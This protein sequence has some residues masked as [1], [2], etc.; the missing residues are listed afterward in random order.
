VFSLEGEWDG[1]R[2]FMPGL[3]R[4]RD[5][6]GAVIDQG[7]LPVTGGKF[8]YFFDPKRINQRVPTYDIEYRVNGRAELGD[9]VHLTF[10]TTEKHP[11]GTP[12]HSFA[13]IILRGN[14]MVVE[15]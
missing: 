6:R 2:G 3:P 7:Y 14:R 13:R 5:S 1:H 10:F 9:I 11:N 12:Y 8:E 4:R 15:R